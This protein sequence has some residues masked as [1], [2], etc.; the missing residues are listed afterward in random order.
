MWITLWIT[1]ITDVQV[2]SYQRVFFDNNVMVT[3]GFDII[4]C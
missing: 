3:M 4:L 1:D 2:T